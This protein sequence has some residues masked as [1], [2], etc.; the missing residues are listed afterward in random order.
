[1]LFAVVIAPRPLAS[2]FLKRNRILSPIC[3]AYLLS[4]DE[5]CKAEN[6]KEKRK[7]RN[8]DDFIDAVVNMLCTFAF[9]SCGT[10]GTANK[11]ST[12]FIFLFHFAAFIFVYNR[13]IAF[14][15]Q[16]ER[17]RKSRRKKTNEMKRMKSRKNL[18]RILFVH[19]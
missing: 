17:I 18:F 10:N 4:I 6:G 11:F 12:I 8:E 14:T 5:N 13:K 3:M 2:Q 16:N 9:S 19:Y 1:M 7:K 15:K